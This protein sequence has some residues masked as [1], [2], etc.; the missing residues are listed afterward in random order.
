[1]RRGDVGQGRLLWAVTLF[2]AAP[3]AIAAVVLAQPAHT[4]RWVL[5]LTTL[6]AV[7]I[8][9]WWLTLDPT[10]EE[11]SRWSRIP[12]QDRGDQARVCL[13][14]LDLGEARPSSPPR[15]GQLPTR[16]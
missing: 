5:G 3:L 16:P 10:P 13:V 8:A 1:M 11:R 2:L 9:I 6:L 7:A 12:V 4:E 14:V 15:T